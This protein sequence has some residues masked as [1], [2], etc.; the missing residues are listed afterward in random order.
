VQALS[1]LSETTR[2]RVLRRAVQ[3][4]C[5][6]RSDLWDGPARLLATNLSPLGLWLQSELAPDTGERLLLNFTPPRWP[7]HVAPVSVLGEVVRVALPRRRDDR[8]TAGV[9][10]QFVDLEDDAAALMTALLRGLPP[11]LPRA[12]GVPVVSHA[13]SVEPWLGLF[14]LDAPFAPSVVVPE[15]RFVLD[16]GTVLELCAE[17][18][19]LTFGRPRPRVEP[20]SKPAAVRGAPP[21]R[22]VARRGS[23]KIPRLRLAS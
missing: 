11:P 18:P 20:S 14:E 13:A 17:G 23:R 21:R 9:G 22:R 6:V 12:C 15:P 7:E 10:I 8:G 2:R 3:V 19:L 4:E 5:A 16:D 1:E